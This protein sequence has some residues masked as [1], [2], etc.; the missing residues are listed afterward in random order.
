M[1]WGR[2]LKMH[3]QK[4]LEAVMNAWFQFQ[5]EDGF[6]IVTYLL[7]PPKNLNINLT[8]LKSNYSSYYLF[9]LYFQHRYI[10]LLKDEI[11][12]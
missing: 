3:M 11:F 9:C 10:E 5:K 12:H 7:R 2:I 8:S 1:H 6:S 4:Y